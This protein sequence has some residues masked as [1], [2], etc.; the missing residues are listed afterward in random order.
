MWLMYVWRS[1]D[2]DITKLVTV[3]NRSSHKIVFRKA[4][5]EGFNALLVMSNG[6]RLKESGERGAT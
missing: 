1:S 6:R 4:E 3:D 2:Y 5:L